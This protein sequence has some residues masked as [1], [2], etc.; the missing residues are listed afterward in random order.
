MKYQRQIKIMRSPD[1]FDKDRQQIFDCKTGDFLYYSK[2]GQTFN[3]NETEPEQVEQ[4]Q[5][6]TNQLNLFEL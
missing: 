5:I 3:I 1:M 4:D 2:Y 6:D